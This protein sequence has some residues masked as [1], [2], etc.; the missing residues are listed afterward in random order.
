MQG[1]VKASCSASCSSLKRKMQY[2]LLI[3]ASYVRISICWLSTSDYNAGWHG[4]TKNV[5]TCVVIGT[6]GRKEDHFATNR[7][8]ACIYV[9]RFILH[10]CAKCVYTRG[11]MPRVFIAFAHACHTRMTRVDCL[12]CG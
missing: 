10:A 4:C 2:T 8:Y 3:T 9:L 7:Y 5:S 11:L 6:T 12:S 1:N